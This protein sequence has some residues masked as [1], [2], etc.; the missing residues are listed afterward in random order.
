[1]ES[2]PARLEKTTKR[3]RMNDRWLTKKREKGKKRTQVALVFAKNLGGEKKN[4]RKA[5]GG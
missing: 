5:R 4:K 1:M 2:H 3:M